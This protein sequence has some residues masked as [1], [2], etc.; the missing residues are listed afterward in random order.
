MS[1]IQMRFSSDALHMVTAADVILP[2]PRDVN[3]PVRE[4][5]TLMLLHGMGDGHSSWLRKTAVERYA[6][7]HGLAVIMP[8]GGLSCYENMAHGRR[9]R[10]YICEELPERMRRTFPLSADR[11]KN[12]I[13][14]CSMGGFGALKLGLANPGKW[15]VI[16]CLS[17]AHFEYQPPSPK[18]QQM[19]SMVYGEHLA[20]F[21][22]A[23]EQDARACAI[24]DLP[25]RILHSCG[26][27]DAL[28]PNALKS[29]EFFEALPT[30][31]IDYSFEMLPGRHDWALWDE[32]IRRFIDRLNLPKPEV[33][34]L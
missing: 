34:L 30:G 9:Y 5:P 3:H 6:L 27:A 1:V 10:E 17:A 31:C 22:A 16:G 26:D 19:L 32:G 2:L 14:G 8:D 4:L 11:E 12:F 18:N 29:R 20:E 13:A 15:S 28:K 23:I 25:L 7:E 21:E 24:G 33:R